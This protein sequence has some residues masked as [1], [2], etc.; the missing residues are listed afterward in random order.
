MP[1]SGVYEVILIIFMLAF[2][3]LFYL[4]MSFFKK[5]FE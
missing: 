3:L 1:D 2:L 5:D 4:L